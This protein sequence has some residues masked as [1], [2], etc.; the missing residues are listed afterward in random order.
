MHVVH[1]TRASRARTLCRLCALLALCARVGR[2]GSDVG[3]R[4]GRGRR[5]LRASL[6]LVI[7]IGGMLRSTRCS[8]HQREG[9]GES[10]RE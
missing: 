1:S 2:R 8:L 7:V 6:L 5:Q 9:E 3:R 4:R 10:E